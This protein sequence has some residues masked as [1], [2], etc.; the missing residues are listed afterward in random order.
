MKRNFDELIKKMDIDTTTPHG[1]LMLGIIQAVIEFESSLAKEFES[2]LA[3]LRTS[4]VIEDQKKISEKLK[5]EA[6]E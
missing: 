5:K 3:K 4:E 2:S 1:K 6:R